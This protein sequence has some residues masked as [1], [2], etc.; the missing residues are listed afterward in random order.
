MIDKDN[1]P[2]PRTDAAED[3]CQWTGKTVPGEFARQLERE[4]SQAIKCINELEEKDILNSE[5][6]EKLSDNIIRLEEHVLHY[7]QLAMKNIETC[8]KSIA[9]QQTTASRYYSLKDWIK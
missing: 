5:I 8:E 9:F 6:M 2:T 7:K 3:W 4:L 1:L